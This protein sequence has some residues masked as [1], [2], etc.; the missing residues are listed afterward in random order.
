MKTLLRWCGRIA[1]GLILLLALV[2]AG[3]AATVWWTL[4]ARDGHFDIPGLSAPV[5]VAFDEYGIPRISA[6]AEH[7]AW[8]AL[9]WLHARDRMFQMEMMRRGAS[10]RLAE[11]T[12]SGGL[13]VDRFMRLLGLVPRAEA[14]LAALPADVR[15]ALEA[16]AR[17]VNAWIAR[18]GRFAGPEFVL[19]GA[20]EPWRPVDSLLWGKVMGL[21]L[22]GNWRTELDRARL[23]AILPPERLEDLW[24]RDFSAG[25]PDA[26]EMQAAL[27]PAEAPPPAV[28]PL[29]G[30]ERLEAALP[31]FPE[32]APLPSMASNAW[33]VDGARSATGAPLLA[34]DPH[35]GFGAPILWYLARIELPGGRILAGASAPG[36]PG[37]VI[38]RSDRLAWGFTTTHSDTQDVFVERLAGPDAYE[39]PEGPRTFTVREEVI[40]VRWGAPVTLRVRETRHGPVVSDLD[41]PAG[42]ADGTVLAVAMA[43]LQ[44]GDTAAAGLIALNGA[45][46]IAEAREAARLITSPSQNL[47]VADADGGIAM[48]LTGRAPVRRSGDGSRP[49]PGWDGSADWT[50]FAPFEALPHVERPASGLIANANNRIVPAGHGVFLGRDWPG[51]WRFRRIGALLDGPSR[52]DAAGFAAMQA[53]RYSLFA[54]EVLPALRAAPR[55]PGAA[56]AAHDILSAWQG[57]MEAARAEPLLFHAALARFGRGL[58]TRAGLPEDAWRASPE[59]LRRVLTDAATGAAWCGEAGCGP[60]LS[61]ALARAVAD[62]APVHGPDPAAWRWGPAH[63]ARFEHSLLRFLPGL[64]ALTRITTPTGGDGETVARAGLGPEVGG[65]FGNIHG[66]GFRGVFDLADPTATFVVIATGQSGHPMSQHWADQVPAW[67]DGVLLRLGPVEGEPSGRIRLTP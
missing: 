22:S 53:D 41:A 36:V 18:R 29:A 62:L 32:D 33:T 5:E 6:R 51:D 21:W 17:G 63:E 52:P 48:F 2:V 16:Y 14:D 46:S 4:P 43:N 35:L 40:Q 20:P 25:R 34:S 1:G 15:A 39:T 37:I 30:L 60:L 61:A 64:G 44:P 49:V 55:P 59:F 8:A 19:L 57:G 9:G 10:G 54:A 26:P 3:V 50:G 45:R 42:R 7:D 56:G 13:R 47:M 11:V 58:L 12:G 66:A 38:G 27:A 28:P 23:A 24:P 65:R 31:R 67:R